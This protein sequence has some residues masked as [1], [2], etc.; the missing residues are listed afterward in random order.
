[1]ASTFSISGVGSGIDFNMIRDAIL[2]SRSRPITQLQTKVGVYNSRIDA[3]KQLNTNLASLTSAAQALTN[4]DLGTG[5]TASSSDSNVVTATANSTAAL[6]QIDLNVTRLATNLSQAS[7]SFSSINAPVLAGGAAS[8]TFELRKGGAATG[9]A[10]TIDSSNNTLAGLRDAINRA[11]AGVTAS[12]VDL[13]GDGTE[14]QLVLNSKETG[15]A[16]RIELVETSSTGTAADLNLRSLN[17]PDGDF[18]KL[19]AAL[20][21]NNLPITRSTNTVSDAVSG[22]TLTLKKTGTTSVNVNASTEISDKLRAF[23]NS[24]NAIQEFVAGQ[25]KKDGKGR[26][27][28]ALAGETTLQNAQ[29]QLRESIGTAS[30]NNGGTFKSLAEIGITAG[31]DG[32]L[33]LDATVL[34]DKLKTNA[35][36]V[37]ALLFGKT[38]TQ[39]GIFQNVQAIAEN[40]SNTT[41]GSIQTAIN[42]YQSSIQNINDTITNRLEIINRM[43]ETMTK[44]FAAADSAIGLLNSQSSSIT[45]ILKSLQKSDS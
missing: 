21:V 24:Y 7:R 13:R 4:R 3:L 45:N 12:I 34:S 25:Y 43:R 41:T 33:S 8:A 30:E 37:R 1:M 5:R 11:N 14:Q 42:G 32:K 29:R 2:A 39:K 18:A 27:T 6:G 36:D 23:V 16:G 10:I 9:T 19:D 31:E 38:S 35:E 26:P 20:T 15:A 28:G 22:V 17:P 40:L 44:Q